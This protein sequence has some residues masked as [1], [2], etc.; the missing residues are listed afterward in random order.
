MRKK[1]VDETI[2]ITP[3]ADKGGI[4]KTT[5]AVNT[6][7]GLTRAGLRGVL[8]DFD[9]TCNASTSLLNTKEGEKHEEYKD[10][11][12]IFSSDTLFDVHG[13]QVDKTVR[14]LINGAPITDVLY[15]STEPNLKIIPSCKALSLTEHELSMKPMG[16]TAL[17]KAIQPLKKECDFIM[18]DTKPSL[19]WLPYNTL[20]AANKVI[21]PVYEQFSVGA[22]NQILGTIYQLEQ[23]LDRELP[24]DGI[25]STKYDKRTNS[26]KDVRD[27]IIERYGSKVY[28]TIIWQDVKL[29]YCAKE[30]KSIFEY[31][32]EHKC[33][34]KG[35]EA[36]ERFTKELM[37][38][39]GL[40]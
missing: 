12:P 17:N 39:W 10:G 6:A 30:H 31:V 36:Y 40:I 3:F 14:D 1:I 27:T 13:N 32:S 34:S 4:G 25:L 19:G 35:A 22:V 37:I 16:A 18:T 38:K 15:D 2:V 33:E 7:A 8:I 20:Y 21:V 9:S 28:E 11:C 23:Q 29:L 24:I 26:S 5:T